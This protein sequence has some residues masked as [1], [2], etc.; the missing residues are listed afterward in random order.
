MGSSTKIYTKNGDRGTTSLIG[1]NKVPK[2]HPRLEAYGTID[3]L[4]CYLGLLM[5]LEIKPAHKKSLLV[6]QDKLMII[7]SHLACTNKKIEKKLPSLSEKEITLLEKFIDQLEEQLPP[8]KSLLLPGGHETVSFC[9][10]ARAVCRRAERRICSLETDP[11]ILIFMNR[12]SDFLFVLSRKIAHDSG[13]TE[14]KWAIK[15]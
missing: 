8:L 13:I 3:E 15:K 5:D 12:L 6:I 2:N 9:H 4:N 7:S 14:K 10:I 1:G 11:L